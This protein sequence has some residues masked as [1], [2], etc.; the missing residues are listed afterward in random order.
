MTEQVLEL[1]AEYGLET[2][3]IALAVNFLTAVVKLPIKLLAKKAENR[4]AVTRFIVFL[5]IVLAFLLT[6]CYRKWAFGAI[7]F[8][9][10]F[11]TLWLSSSSLSLTVYAVFEKMIPVPKNADKTQAAAPDPTVEETPIA[12]QASAEQPPE[13][14]I[15]GGKRREITPKK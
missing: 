8:D 5:P 4:H 9:K 2:V 12:P 10:A 14:L 13:K 3:G 1:I 11:V 6:L 15:L 7:A